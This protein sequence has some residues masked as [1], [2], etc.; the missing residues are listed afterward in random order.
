LH[1]GNLQSLTI[2]FISG[3]GVD[4]RIFQKLQLPSDIKAVHLKWI[5]PVK[6]ESLQHYALRL[7]DSIN[8]SEE[9]SIIGLSFG[10][11]I[12]TEIAKVLRPKTTVLLS[13]VSSKDQLPTLYRMAGSIYLNKIIPGVMLKLVTPFTYWLFGAKTIDE[14]RLLKNIISATD[15]SFLKWAINAILS[16]NNQVVPSSVVRIH[17]T[18]DKVIPVKRIKADHMVKRGEHIMVYTKADEISIILRTLLTN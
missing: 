6:D 2:Y 9:F 5:K 12:A 11:M 8:K 17:G 14:K 3:L 16:W 18:N 1:F 13:S 4:E 10:G 15:P 7:A